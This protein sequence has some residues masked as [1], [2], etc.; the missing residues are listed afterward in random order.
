MMLIQSFP[1]P[2]S[3]PCFDYQLVPE[4]NE[5]TTYLVYA[6]QRDYL[7]VP[8]TH[9]VIIFYDALYRV[10]DFDGFSSQ[11]KRSFQ[12]PGLYTEC[13]TNCSTNDQGKKTQKLIALFGKK[14]IEIKCR[15][16][17]KSDLIYHQA[18]SVAALNYYLDKN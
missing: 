4:D 11:E 15:H 16:Y 7:S 5:S 10:L 14:Y 3:E 18:D 13:A 6:I 2:Q 12:A 1:P 17:K 8:T 9:I